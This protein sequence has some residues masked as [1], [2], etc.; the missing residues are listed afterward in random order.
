MKLIIGSIA[1][2]ALTG[3]AT[4]GAPGAPGAVSPP[5]ATGRPAQ[6]SLADPQVRQRLTADLSGKG[7]RV[8]GTTSNAAPDA[9][10]AG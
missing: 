5:A 3:C 2:A 1:L 4:P 8:I 9:E 10:P 7:W 6:N